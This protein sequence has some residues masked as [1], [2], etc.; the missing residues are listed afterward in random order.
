[1]TDVLSQVALLFIYFNEGRIIFVT[2]S[3]IDT[4]G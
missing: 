4:K 1:M 3:K 2:F